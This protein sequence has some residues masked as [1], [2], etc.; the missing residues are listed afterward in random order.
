MAAESAA[1]LYTPDLLS[2]ATELA[3]YPV[4][5]DWNEFTE[6]RSQ[7]CGSSLG[8]GINTDPQGAI[9]EFGLA[10]TACAVGQAAAAIFA[11]GARSLDRDHCDEAF[12]QLSSWLGSSDAPPPDWPD[13]NLLEN[14][15]G[16]PGRHGAILLPWK[17][18]QQA[19]CKVHHTR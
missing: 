5:G 3:Q 10:V 16:Y 15:R 12:T 2:L 17:A 6:V 19:L 8:L 14:A 9:T 7:T 4:A 18:A 13:I 11:R 1:K